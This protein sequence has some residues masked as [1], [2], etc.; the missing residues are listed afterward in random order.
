M[1][2]A[3]CTGA[4]A[5]AIMGSAL[6]SAAP[7]GAATTPWWQPGPIASW[8]YVIGE[9][10]PLA[11]PTNLGNVQVYDSDAGITDGLSSTG[12]PIA[13]GTIESSE[14]AIHAAGSRSICY[15]DVGGAENYRSDYS[16][17]D[18]SELGSAEPGWPNEQWVNV[19]DWSMPVPAPYETLQTIMTNRIS[20]CKQEGFDAAEPDNGDAYANAPLGGFTLTMQQ[21]EAFLKE[22]ASIAHGDGLAIFLKNGVNGDS[23]VSDMAP[24]VDG[25]INEQCWQYNECSSLEIF[26]QAGK[27][28]LNVEYQ[29]FAESTLCPQANAFPMAT[30][31]TDVNLDGAIVYGCWQYGAAGQTTAST[32][33]APVTGATWRT[34]T[35]TSTAAPPDLPESPWAAGLPVAGAL[36]LG[37][38]IA[39]TRFRRVRRAGRH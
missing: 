37:G 3:F 21:D 10:Y 13:D 7:V 25:A 34:T 14:S 9:N 30:T 27:P 38:G 23:F 5:V 19:A 11:I 31:H 12:M 24:Y 26:V 2:R 18:P 15:L 33:S 6:V 36:A 32:A 17:F 22:L 35:T 1:I 29:N 20:L 8:A 28:V 16:L 39:L 4:A